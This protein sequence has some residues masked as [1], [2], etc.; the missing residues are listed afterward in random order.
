MGLFHYTFFH[1]TAQLS[2][3]HFAFRLSPTQHYSDQKARL[4]ACQLVPNVLLAWHCPL[5]LA[6][7]LGK[8][9]ALIMEKKTGRFES[10]AQINTA[11]HSTTRHSPGQVE[12]RYIAFLS[13]PIPSY[14][15]HFD[16]ERHLCYIN[17][18]L[19]LMG[20]EIVH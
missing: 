16:L 19:K 1:G 3:Q 4:P 7:P 15:T 5:A 9:H 14:L 6:P 2:L 8:K 10:R 12:K 11:C 20:F 17:T 18:A 13:I